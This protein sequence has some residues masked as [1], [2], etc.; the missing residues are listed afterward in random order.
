MG[1]FDPLK[2]Y[3]APR[4]A[5]AE[6]RKLQ[7]IAEEKSPAVLQHEYDSARRA[8]LGDFAST[9]ASA[10]QAC[11][12]NAKATRRRERLELVNRAL[13]SCPAHAKAASRLRG[14]MDEVEHMRC[15]QHVY[16]ANAPQLPDDL[17]TAAPPG[18]LKPSDEELTSLGLD[19]KMLNPVNSNFRAAVYKKDP[20]VWGENP[21][22]PYTLAFRGSTPELEDWQ[23]NFAQDANRASSY[24]ER[25]VR[26]GNQ[27]A[28]SRAD[29]HIVGH[30]QGGGLASA[31]QGGSGLTASTYNAAG[32]HPETVA[33]YLQ[34]INHMAAEAHKIAA[35]RV[36]GEVLTKIQE[37]L[38]GSRG[39]SMLANDA[40]GIKR[41]LPAPT[42]AA[43]FAALVRDG[44][45]VKGETHDGYLHGMDQVIAAMEKQKAA[46]EAALKNC[47]NGENR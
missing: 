41:D 25:A 44:K 17:R 4:L 33:R 39:L 35:I 1:L 9:P 30:S 38:I 26:I 47:L 23:N 19:D 6:A 27:L 46:D 45:Q 40:V 20:A 7:E 21:R 8:L 36:E 31:A 32:L 3:L 29:V 10:C 34:D 15:A 13:V 37:N 22:P 28:L 24:Y 18:F 43:E 5:A 16:L 14:D 11:M 2:G 12:A 42:D